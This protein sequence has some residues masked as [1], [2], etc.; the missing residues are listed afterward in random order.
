M[1]AVGP[2]GSTARRNLHEDDINALLAAYGPPPALGRVEVEGCSFSGRT[3]ASR[4]SSMMT[5]ILLSLL[6]IRRR[7]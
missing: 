3:T 1:Y 4:G 2:E 7:K 6:C 5:M